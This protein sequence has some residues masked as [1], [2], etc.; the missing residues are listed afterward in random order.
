MVARNPILVPHTLL[1][2]PQQLVQRPSNHPNIFSLLYEHIALC[3]LDTLLPLGNNS[4]SIAMRTEVHSAPTC[5]N[6]FPSAS[7]NSTVPG[8]WP[9]LLRTHTRTRS[10]HGRSV[11]RTPNPKP[12]LRGDL[13]VCRQP[14]FVGLHQVLQLLLYTFCLFFPPLC[15]SRTKTA[16]SPV[17]VNKASEHIDGELTKRI[18]VS[19]VPQQNATSAQHP[20]HRDCSPKHS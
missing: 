19:C 6:P 2:R 1:R 12:H 7:Y 11:E 20:L 9:S 4:V 14:G 5:G 13:L 16:C 3:S 17:K 18:T 8:S 10:K 15:S